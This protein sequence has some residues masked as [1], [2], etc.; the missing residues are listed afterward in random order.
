[1]AV[2]SR[3]LARTLLAAACI[4]ALGP[5][6]RAQ[7]LPDLG[8]ASSATLSESQERTIGNRIMREVRVDP[9]YIDDPDIADYISGL[10]AR[11][12][13][14][15]ETGRR[16]LNFFAVQDDVV[17]AFA[18]VGG[19]IGIHTGLILLTQTESELAGVMAHEVA[20]ITQR[21]Q[22]RSS[23]TRPTRSASRSCSRV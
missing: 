20:H 22:A 18:M 2:P 6:P 5:G 15:A 9:A 1:M 16:D 7:G 4:A 21:H 12:L 11:L 13:G 8:D 3:K 10:G 14:V 23:I 19:H 17:N